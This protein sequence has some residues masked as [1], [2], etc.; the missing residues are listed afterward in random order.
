MESSTKKVVQEL[1]ENTEAE[2]VPLLEAL[3]YLYPCIVK[4]NFFLQL[5]KKV[6]SLNSGL[7]VGLVTQ[8]SSYEFCN[9]KD[10]K[11]IPVLLMKQLLLCN[12]EK[13][14]NSKGNCLEP[15]EKIRE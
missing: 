6:Q 13:M 3:S 14:R 12:R 15:L 7:A 11:G 10:S 9:K 4:N 2:H 5:P 8:A 1:Q